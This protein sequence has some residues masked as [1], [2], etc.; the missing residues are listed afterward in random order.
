[1]VFLAML[2]VLFDQYSKYYIQSNMVV[3][4][5]IPVIQDVF[6]LTYILNPGAAFGVLE[7][8]TTFF[9]SVALL[10]IGGIVL[11]YQRITKMHKLLRL[12]VGLLSGGALGNVI[13]R[14][15]LGCVVDFFDFRI[16]PVFNVADIAIVMGVACIIY[17]LLFV[18]ED[19]LSK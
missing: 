2:V 4:H 14:V 1:M 18:A 10:M 16:W 17:V 12:G 13:D 3:G 7:Y 15:R 11:F 6:H 9:V 8:K 19:T 5:S